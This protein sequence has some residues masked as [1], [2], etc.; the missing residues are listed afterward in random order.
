MQQT[1]IECDNCKGGGYK[2]S[3][4][5]SKESMCLVCEGGGELSVCSNF[6]PGKVIAVFRNSRCVCCGVRQNDHKVSA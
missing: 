1:T 3:A 4:V 6:D 2:F 5:T